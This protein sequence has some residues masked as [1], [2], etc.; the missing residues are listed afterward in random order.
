MAQK[1][2]DPRKPEAIDQGRRR[3]L[4]ATGVAPLA[5]SVAGA[6]VAEAQTGPAIV[7]PGEVPIELMVNGKRVALRV[8]PR[9]TLL[10]AIRNRADITGNKKGCDRGVCGACT[11][12]IDGKTAYS[13]STLAIEAVGKQIRTVDGL[14][15]GSKLH[16]VQQAFCDRDGLMCGFCT[17]GFVMATVALL[18]K[19]PKPTADQVKK[20][21]DG[22]ICR[23]G[24]FVRVMEAAMTASGQLA[25]KGVARG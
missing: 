11:M 15:E 10:N 18:E 25:T 14:A 13:C 4:K 17:P 22:N 23:C 21:L 2:N 9:V 12:I 1:T 20:G 5:A 24:T 16:P 7:G 8:E 3:F 6:A 19:H